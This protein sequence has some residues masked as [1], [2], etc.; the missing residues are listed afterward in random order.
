M[1]LIPKLSHYVSTKI[2]KS[3]KHPKSQ[4][5]LVSSISEV[6]LP[7]CSFPSVT[8]KVETT[9]DQTDQNIQGKTSLWAPRP[10]SWPGYP[11][12]L[13]N[14]VTNQPFENQCVILLLNFFFG[15]SL[16]KF[17]STL[18]SYFIAYYETMSPSPGP[19]SQVWLKYLPSGLNCWYSKPI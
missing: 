11:S 17:L 3:K 18:I 8:Y 14:Q 1:G 16:E 13:L 2:L 10:M 12:A 5:I 19:I 4:T 6:A 7:L 9:S 15:L